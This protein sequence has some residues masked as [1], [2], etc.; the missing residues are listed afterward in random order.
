MI[1]IVDGKRKR[2]AGRNKWDDQAPNKGGTIAMPADQVGSKCVPVR[3][4]GKVNKRKNRGRFLRLQ[5]MMITIQRR[6]VGLLETGLGGSSVDQTSFERRT[7]RR[8]PEVIDRTGRQT[9]IETKRLEM[10]Q[11]LICRPVMRVCDCVTGQ[12]GNQDRPNNDEDDDC[13]EW[14]K[15]G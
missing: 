11:L 8:R 4:K 12:N 2:C 3:Q 1:L 13:D 14:T 15:K 6:L 7:E 9:E 5:M 10:H